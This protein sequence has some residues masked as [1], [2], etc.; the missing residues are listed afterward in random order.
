MVVTKTSEPHTLKI[1]SLKDYKMLM[2]IPPDEA[3]KS[4][5]VRFGDRMIVLIQKTKPGQLLFKILDIERKN[6][7][8]EF[9]INFEEKEEHPLSCIEI[10]DKY[11]IFKQDHKEAAVFNYLSDETIQ[12]IDSVD[13][14]PTSFVFMRGE[15]LLAMYE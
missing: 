2:A 13:F 9:D 6:F 8:K 12:P 5:E 4:I 15:R 1:W 7:V 14:N 11:V 10:F 3:A